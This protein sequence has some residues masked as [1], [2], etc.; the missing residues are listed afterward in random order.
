[1]NV[2]P[3]SVNIHMSTKLDW[4]RTVADHVALDLAPA[5]APVDASHGTYDPLWDGP[6]A[7]PA[8]PGDWHSTAAANAT[9]QLATATGALRDAIAGL[10]LTH[11]QP[12]D[13]RDPA[14][15]YATIHVSFPARPEGID[16]LRPFQDHD[17][18]WTVGLRTSL[19]DLFVDPTLAPIVDAARDVLAAT[20]H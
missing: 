9:P 17:G 1:M 3:S 5:S 7:Q 6:Y 13:Q 11:A 4:N 18:T 16:H 19:D 10:D 12:Y 15:S 8:Q 20:P 2:S 14:Q